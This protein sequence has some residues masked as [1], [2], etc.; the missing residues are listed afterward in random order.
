MF[1]RL[2]DQTGTNVRD[3]G[4]FFRFGSGLTVRVGVASLRKT[5]SMPPLGAA[6]PRGCRAV[7]DQSFSGTSRWQSGAQPSQESS[8]PSSHSSSG[9]C[10]TPSPQ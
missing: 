3:S 10:V 7:A 8:L 4:H 9:D 2:G 6:R 5:D 1:V